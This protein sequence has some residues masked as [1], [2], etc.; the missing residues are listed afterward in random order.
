MFVG[1][2][3]LDMNSIEVGSP[4]RE[5]LL[6]EDLK[7]GYAKVSSKKDK[8]GWLQRSR[9][10][11]IGAADA[12]RRAASG[13]SQG[14]EEGRKLE[15]LVAAADG[16][17]WGGYGNGVLVRWHSDGYKREV[18]LRSVGVRSLCMVGIRLWVGYSD[19][20]LHVLDGDTFRAVGSWL[21][22]R[23]AVI[24]MALAG[25]Y[26]FSLGLSGSIRGWNISSPTGDLDKL[27]KAKMT[28]RADSYT[29][30]QHLQV[31]VG[32]WNTAQEKASLQSTRLWLPS[33]LVDE[34]GVVAVGLQ[35]VEMGAGAIGMAA[36]KES[37]SPSLRRS[38]LPFL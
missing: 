31:L 8:G 36:V 18:Q 1:P 30:Q 6:D 24:D 27:I 20:K 33:D 7:V 37:V 28:N 23:L 25:R 29:R 5:I 17:V 11:V 3:G 2:N 9:N 32:S 34:A 14:L 15:A 35:E 10:A 12:V 13:T 16:T 38:R 26:I 22:H 21:A 4:G 19:G